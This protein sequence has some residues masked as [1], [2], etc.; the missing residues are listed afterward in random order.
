[1]KANKKRIIIIAAAVLLA[2]TACVLYRCL[3][4]GNRNP[5][6]DARLDDSTRQ[7]LRTLKRVD[8]SGSETPNTTVRRARTLIRDV[9]TTEDR[10]DND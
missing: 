6:N 10:I 7:S 3:P 9:W 1:M 8:P 4:S 2:V 5:Q